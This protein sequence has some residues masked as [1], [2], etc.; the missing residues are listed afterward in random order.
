M[1]AK[2]IFAV[3]GKE[4]FIFAGCLFNKNYIKYISYNKKDEGRR[5]PQDLAITKFLDRKEKILLKDEGGDKVVKPFLSQYFVSFIENNV[6]PIIWFDLEGGGLDDQMDEIVRGVE[7]AKDRSFKASWM[8]HESIQY[9]TQK[10]YTV[11]FTFYKDAA[12]V[13]R[14][15]LILFEQNFGQAISAATGVDPKSLANSLEKKALIEKYYDHAYSEPLRK[16]LIGL[17]T[18][19][20]SEGS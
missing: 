13:G 3:E 2:G 14:A 15:T 9:L 6:Y 1:S 4:E 12:A 18:D 19:N 17:I 10:F 11:E 7:Q 20:L 5:Q 16:K 8:K